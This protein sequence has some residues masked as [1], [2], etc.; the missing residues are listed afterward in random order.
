MTNKQTPAE[1][2]INWIIS[3]EKRL[4]QEL[5][6]LTNAQQALIEKGVNS[7]T[8]DVLLMTNSAIEFYERVA[9]QLEFAQKVINSADEDLT[10]FLYSAEQ[11][12]FIRSNPIE[13]IARH[14]T[15]WVLGM[16]NGTNGA[17]SNG[18][19]PFLEQHRKNALIALLKEE[20]GF[21]NSTW[22][23]RHAE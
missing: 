15:D 22:G 18:V 4:I 9:D 8:L 11:F 23:L 13:W 5:T 20:F 3:T 6:D 10:N 19:Y 17:G 7:R 21:Y 16:S 1:I 2:V 14:M 12:A